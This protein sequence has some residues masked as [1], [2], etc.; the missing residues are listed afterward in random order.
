MVDE[1][2]VQRCL[3]LLGT[4]NSAGFE[5]A[6]LE[7]CSKDTSADVVHGLLIGSVFAGLDLIPTAK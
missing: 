1:A 7:G 2:A 4:G 3:C 5:K 6:V